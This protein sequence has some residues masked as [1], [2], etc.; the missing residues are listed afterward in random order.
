[1]GI[2][3][4]KN[5]TAKFLLPNSE[6]PAKPI[7]IEL[8]WGDRVRIDVT[9]PASGLVAARARGRDGEIDVDELSDQ[10]LLEVYV[11][12]VGQG[13]GILIRTPDHRHLLIDGGYMRAK[14]PTNKNAAD[15][16]DWKF[17]KDYGSTEIQLEAMIASH[18]DADHYGG[19]W[20]LLNPDE[21]DELD[22]NSV[23]VKDFYH[24]GVGWWKEPGDSAR[25]L[26]RKADGPEGED[27]LVTI[28]EDRH[29]MEAAFASPELVPQGEWGKFLRAML[30]HQPAVE[31]VQRLS[32]K[33]EYLPGFEPVEG[34][35]SIRVLGP[36]EFEVDGNPAVRSLGTNDKNTNGNSV[37]LRLDYGRVRVLLTGDLNAKAQQ[38][39]L[40]HFTGRRTEFAADVVKACH[41]G[42]ADCSFEFLSVIQAGAT[43]ISSGDVES[44]S[45]PRPS[46][47]AAS[48]VTGHRRI[49]RDRLV[50]PL[51]YSTEIS[52]S[53]RIGQRVSVRQD[54]TRVLGPEDAGDVEYSEVASG[55]LRP[56]KGTRRWKGTNVVAGLVY[57]LVNIRT[58]GNQILCATLNENNSTW[59]YEVFESRF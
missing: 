49:D 28:L 3:Y 56:K 40:K 29:Q 59:D 46:I 39:L 37:L 47:V 42:S 58:D 38:E 13:D 18:C 14:Q 11:I 10:S 32:Q 31:K 53:V 30:D 7:V 21:A 23:R 54:G 36:V 35:A 26:G 25:S 1:M 41:H 51:V 17:N 19:L 9:L 4:V 22:C 45:H 8:L 57:G 33:S 24:A 6:N 15:F 52:R 2:H 43:I 5:W 20:D 44:H 50:T 27:Y 55:A 48:A 16:I 34:Q 12:D